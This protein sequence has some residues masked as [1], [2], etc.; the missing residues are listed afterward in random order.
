[1]EEKEEASSISS[2]VG[3]SLGPYTEVNSICLQNFELIASLIKGY[4]SIVPL[5]ME[6][7]KAAIYFMSLRMCV[8]I[9]M[10][11]KRKNLFPDNKYISI[12]EEN[13]R[14]FLIKMREQDIQNMSHELV[15]YVRS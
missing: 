3:S 1:M 10:S 5:S 2:F 6:E 15:D 13:A 9:T 8:S 12:S 4:H 7:L 11:A 14:K